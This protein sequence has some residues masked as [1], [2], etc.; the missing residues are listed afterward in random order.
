MSSLLHDIRQGLRSLAKNPWF[1]MQALLTLAL[2]IA[3][4]TVIFTMVN[5]VLLRGLQFRE[6]RFSSTSQRP[7]ACASILRRGSQHQ[8]KEVIRAR[9][10]LLP[11]RLADGRP[12]DFSARV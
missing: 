4:N 3:A 1:A 10:A 8:G 2:G 6:V 9:W 7:R 5:S 12:Y 11:S